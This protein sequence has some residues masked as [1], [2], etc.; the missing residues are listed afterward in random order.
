MTKPAPTA[1]GEASPA[2][3]RAVRP[4]R[5]VPPAWVER[6]G[7]RL[8]DTTVLFVIA[9]FAVWAV[10]ALLSGY[11]FTV[12][13]AGEPRRLTVQNQ[14]TGPALAAFLVEHGDDLHRV[15]AARHRAG[16]AARRGRGGALGLH[17]RRAALD[18]RDHAARGC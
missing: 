10:S 4:R 8:P 1:R 15:P 16:G 11:E 3:T 17:Q 5:A 12:P 9:L 7:N 14:L 6:V 2:P 18:A 13:A